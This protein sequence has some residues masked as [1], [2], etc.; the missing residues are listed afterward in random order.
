MVKLVTRI[1][2]VE[3]E[4]EMGM[5]LEQLRISAQYRVDRTYAVAGACSRLERHRYDLVVADTRLPDGTG[6][7]VANRA[8]ATGT[9]ALI[10]SG[11]RPVRPDE[12]LNDLV[13]LM[14]SPPFRE[15]GIH[16]G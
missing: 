14:G 3:D 1:L 6:M 8:T 7:D 16:A 4:E 11:L 9:K 15:V 10:V 5:L 13:R 2:L 12:L